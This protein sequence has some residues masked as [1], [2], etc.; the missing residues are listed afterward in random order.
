MIDNDSIYFIEVCKTLSIK[1]AAKNCN[2][3]VSTISKSLKRI[4]NK[5]F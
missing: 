1:N 4:E 2:I 3:D 5:A